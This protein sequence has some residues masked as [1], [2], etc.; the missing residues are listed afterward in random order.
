M[1]YNNQLLHRFH[2]QLVSEAQSSDDWVGLPSMHQVEAKYYN[3]LPPDQEELVIFM[4]TSTSANTQ[5][6][7][8]ILTV[9]S[10]FSALI[11]RGNDT[12]WWPY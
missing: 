2:P 10:G 3:D 4:V 1:K 7:H 6:M 11:K 8:V 9:S 5:I 12:P